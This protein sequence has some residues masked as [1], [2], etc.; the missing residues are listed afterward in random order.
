MWHSHGYA[1]PLINCGD[2]AEN[3]WYRDNT[4]NSHVPIQIKMNKDHL[5]GGT[6]GIL[7]MWYWQH[8]RMSHIQSLVEYCIWANVP[9]EVPWYHPSW[10]DFS[11]GILWMQ[12]SQ[13]KQALIELS[14]RCTTQGTLV[15]S[16]E[17][18]PQAWANLGWI[19]EGSS[20]IVTPESLGTRYQF[21]L[22]VSLY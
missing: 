14:S 5:W 12:Y 16:I 7:C 18:C 17:Y 15:L 8:L 20:L 2:K 6:H 13:H 21:L 19:R 22:G 3:I 4:W 9:Q 1:I 10:G 11:Y